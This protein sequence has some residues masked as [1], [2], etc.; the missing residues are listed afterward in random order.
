[1]NTLKAKQ[2]RKPYSKPL[3]Q[4]VRL[5]VSE[6]VLGPESCKSMASISAMGDDFSDCMMAESVGHCVTFDMYAS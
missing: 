3:V 4:E 5:R 6:A 2:S 1:M